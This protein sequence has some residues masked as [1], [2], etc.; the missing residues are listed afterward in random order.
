MMY[1]KHITTRFICFLCAFDVIA[2]RSAFVGE[3]YGFSM[4]EF[5]CVLCIVACTAKSTYA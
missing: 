5:L 3:L 4:V 1:Y 2:R